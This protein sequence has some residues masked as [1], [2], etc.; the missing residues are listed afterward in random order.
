MPKLTL[1][2]EP[3]VIEKAKK[4]AHERGTSVSALFSQFVRSASKPDDASRPTL[5][6]ITRR[7]AGIAKLS[8]DKPYREL[9]E[10]AIR[11]KHGR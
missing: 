10:K 7:A 8:S 6:P 2:A 4:M 9:I 3:D 1:N 11:D 5:G